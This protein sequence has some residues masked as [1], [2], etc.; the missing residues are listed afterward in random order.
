MASLRKSEIVL[1]KQCAAKHYGQV[2]KEAIKTA[3][4]TKARLFSEKIYVTFCTR[5]Y[6]VS[7]QIR[8]LTMIEGF[9]GLIK[10][11]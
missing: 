9:R 8:S 7:E 10:F 4:R 3:H 1:R 11:E 5:L 2:V 6:S